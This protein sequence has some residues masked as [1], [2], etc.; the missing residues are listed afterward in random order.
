MLNVR[1]TH[2]SVIGYYCSNVIR[3]RTE[4]ERVP[5]STTEPNDPYAA[6]TREGLGTQIID[7]GLKVAHH[8]GLAELCLEQLC[9]FG[10]KSAVSLLPRGHLREKM[11]HIHRQSYE[12]GL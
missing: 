7:S 4:Q 2:R 10:A 1:G 11:E 8:A 6:G 3:L 5:A 9:R 12:T